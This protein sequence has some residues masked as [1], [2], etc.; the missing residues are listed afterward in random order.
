MVPQPLP[1]YNSSTG[2]G[3]TPAASIPQQAPPHAP[4]ET[5]SFFSP[6]VMDYENQ[7]YFLLAAFVLLQ[8][9]KLA[10]VFA[11]NAAGQP[12]G[13]GV[14]FDRVTRLIKWMLG[15]GLFLAAVKFLRVP[16]L[17]YPVHPTLTCCF[18]LLAMLNIAVLFRHVVVRCPCGG[19]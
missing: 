1:G 15:D 10:D 2:A 17:T 19:C 9:F 6:S 13:W 3:E 7:R 11:A 12:L 5:K 16:K 18:A 8:G 14:T 4:E